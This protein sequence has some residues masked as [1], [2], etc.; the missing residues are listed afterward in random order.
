MYGI[1][2]RPE[3]WKY[4]D[5]LVTE[6]NETI[7]YKTI[8]RDVDMYNELQKLSKISVQHL[9]IDLSCVLDD[10]KFIIALRQYRMRHENTQ[11]I[12]ISP[13]SKQGDPLLH[14]LASTISIYDIIANHDDLSGEQL[15][16]LLKG[17][18]ESPAKYRDGIRWMNVNSDDSEDV[19][20]KNAEPT[21]K[22]IFQVE[23]KPIKIT[24]YKS[25]MLNSKNIVFSGLHRGSGSS[26]I[27]TLF[28]GYLNKKKVSNALIEIPDISKPPFIYDYLG[29]DKLASLKEDHF[30]SILNN[31][32]NGLP[33][34][35]VVKYENITFAI[36]DPKTEK[37]LD[38]N[39]YDTSRLLL[40]LDDS[41]IKIIDGDI[42]L[43]S[44]NE[45]VNFPNTIVFLVVDCL[46]VHFNQYLDVIEEYK[47]HSN[48]YLIINKKN[49]HM[50]D[51]EY[52]KAIPNFSN[53]LYFP[54]IDFS[55]I[56]KA[57]YNNSLLVNYK[58]ILDI[59]EDPL[60]EIGHKFMS[61]DILKK[62]IAQKKSF[63]NIKNKIGDV[64]S[65][66]SGKGEKE[67][68]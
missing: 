9:L 32:K 13:E 26:T 31:S 46:P 55:M 64:V 4:V 53:I 66:I 39:I 58:E 19:Q 24:E 7:V 49:H 38:W 15:S 63:F 60:L 47:N 51:S 44:L 54:L 62:D 8:S 27:A 3:Y 45:L 42:N 30:L 29:I 52:I 10:K 50:K 22:P 34:H 21:K 28:S 2:C 14:T 41:P 17:A 16:Q 33:V 37:I 12:I 23:G 68:E 43:Q 57:S 59:V 56:Y 67:L 25:V 20:H 61:S 48:V 1:I 18:I 11:I 36:Q 6:M 35:D 40:S 65:S 5:E